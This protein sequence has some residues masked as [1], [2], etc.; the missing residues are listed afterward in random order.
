MQHLDCLV[1][2]HAGS[3]T[4]GLDRRPEAE[5][6]SVAKDIALVVRE[7]VLALYPI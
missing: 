2:P 3:P 1:R 6:G 5:C 4:L 7:D